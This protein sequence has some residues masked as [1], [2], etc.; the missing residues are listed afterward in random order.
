V[1]ANG[2]IDINNHFVALLLAEAWVIAEK[3]AA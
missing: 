3:L 1:V 2:E